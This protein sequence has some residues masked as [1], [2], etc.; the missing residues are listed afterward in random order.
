MLTVI[1]LM[2]CT[3]TYVR[4]FLPQFLDKH[5]TGLVLH[6]SWK[7]TSRALH[8]ICHLRFRGIFWKFARIGTRFLFGWK[9]ALKSNFLVFHLFLSSFT[10]KFY[11]RRRAKKSLCL[12]VLDRN[13]SVDVILDI[14]LGD[15]IRLFGCFFNGIVFIYYWSN[16]KN[17]Y[18]SKQSY[19]LQE[20][21][22]WIFYWKILLF[23]SNGL[24]S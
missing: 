1:L 2:I 18:F 24:I 8:F 16:T 7:D 4:A 11:V 5:K 3:C 15:W 14:K 20:K 10:K 9:I 13:G 12:S 21:T 17:L 22:K 6:E 23:L 19:F